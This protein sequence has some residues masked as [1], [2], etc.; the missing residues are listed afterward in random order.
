LTELFVVAGALKYR[1]I[2]GHSPAG[3]NICPRRPRLSAPAYIGVAP[4]LNAAVVE[5]GFEVA[6][7]PVGN[8][9]NNDPSRMRRRRTKGFDLP[10]DSATAP[11]PRFA[12][13]SPLEEAGFEPSVPRETGHAEMFV[14]LG[15]Q[16]GP[17]MGSAGPFAVLSGL[18]QQD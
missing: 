9:K 16:T 5:Y 1:G 2:A 18:S 17:P 8:V 13:D 12:P 11:G 3:L 6:G 4:D 10:G 15:S 14:E 7:Q